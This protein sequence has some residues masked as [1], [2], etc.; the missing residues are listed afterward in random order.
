M[1][2]F[3]CADKTLSSGFYRKLFNSS[4]FYVVQRSL[5]LAGTVYEMIV[6]PDYE[7]SGLHS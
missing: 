1:I 7:P 4:Y 5:Y 3:S 6:E 2:G